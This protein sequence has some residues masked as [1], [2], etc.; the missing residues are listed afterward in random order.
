MPPYYDGYEEESQEDRDEA[1]AEKIG[2][3]NKYL[4]TQISLE[5]QKTYSR[6]QVAGRIML[7][8]RKL[9]QNISDPKSFFDIFV[10][11]LNF[12]YFEEDDEVEEVVGK[13]QANTFTNAVI[14]KLD[15][16]YVAL[17]LVLKGSVTAVL[18]DAN[19]AVMNNVS[20]YVGGQKMMTSSDGQFTLKNM[21]YGSYN[22]NVSYKNDF[23]ALEE[24]LVIGADSGEE[25]V[26]LHCKE[27]S[28]KY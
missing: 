3:L 8:Q 14:A 22:V 17:L 5:D 1:I 2:A 13:L 9:G 28:Y 27:L 19:G 20:V 10:D 21:P 4:N 24:E 11:T 23:E 26:E 12:V 18:F 16:S 25:V 7:Y 15:S 6:Y